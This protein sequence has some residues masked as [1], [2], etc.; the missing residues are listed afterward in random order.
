MGWD[1]T[2]RDEIGRDGTGRDETGWDGTGR[3]GMQWDETR[4]SLPQR[5]SRLLSPLLCALPGAAAGVLGTAAGPSPP[6]VVCPTAAPKDLSPGAGSGQRLVVT[7][8]G[9][10]GEKGKRWVETD[11][12]VIYFREKSFKMSSVISH[13]KSGYTG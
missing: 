10:G 12:P 13:K 4:Y 1:W 11:I 2:G 5:L 6:A 8:K 9:A 3:D 7:G